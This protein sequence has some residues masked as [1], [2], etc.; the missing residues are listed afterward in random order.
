MFP[1]NLPLRTSS[2]PMR[3]ICSVLFAVS[4]LWARAQ[5]TFV[6]VGPSTT[7]A[8]G[9]ALPLSNGVTAV[10]ACDGPVDVNVF[11][12]E[13]GDVTSD[14]V[15]S[16][17][18]GPGV[19]WAVW[20]PL[21]EAPSVAWNFIGDQSLVFYGNGTGRLTGTIQNSVNTTWQM[22]VDMRFESGQSWEDWSG[23]GR[24]FVDEDGDGI[25]DLARDHDGD[26]LPNG[27]DPDWVK[28]KQDGTGAQAGTSQSQGSKRCVRAQQRGNKGSQ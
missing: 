19:D 8:C 10:S 27:Q 15:V 4:F 17:A 26:G 28:N 14:C 7:I 18:V 11:V 25:N 9:D 21:L 16:T 6:N 22:Q 1:F 20:L 23:Q 12:A 13:T 2:M 3:T 24:G 5:P